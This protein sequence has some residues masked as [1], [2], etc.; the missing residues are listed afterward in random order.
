ML[1]TIATGLA[2]LYS[3]LKPMSEGLYDTS[4]WV[5]KI[6]APA[7][8]EDNATT[9][10]LIKFC[11]AALMDGWLSDIPFITSMLFFGCIVVAFCH[12]WWAGILMYCAAVLLSETTKLFFM[13][14]VSYYLLFLHHKMINR[15]ADYKLKND[16]ER[17]E[18]CDSF[19][20]DLETIIA[21]YQDSRLKPP[22]Q[23]QLKAIPYGD[24]NYWLTANEAN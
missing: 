3:L 17:L 13:R 8:S 7:D 12:R 14:S 5:A 22:T 21:I 6:L 16:L 2:I 18:A 10:Q 15:R 20:R 19:S 4:M 11:Q 23:K 9:R 1:I 24:V